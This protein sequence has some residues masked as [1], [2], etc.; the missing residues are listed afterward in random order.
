MLGVIQKQEDYVSPFFF[1]LIIADEAHR[2]LFNTFKEIID[3][4]DCLR[5]VLPPLRRTRCASSYD[6]FNCPNG[7]PTYEYSFEEAVERVPLRLRG[8]QGRTESS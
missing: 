5:S 4:F 8:A 2:S 7:I 6:L 1:D 3:Y